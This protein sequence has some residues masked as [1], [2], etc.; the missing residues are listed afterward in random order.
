MIT[1]MRSNDAYLGLPHDVFCFTMIQEI[2]A[3]SVSAELGSYTHMV[4][5]LHLYEND[6]RRAETFLNEGFQPTEG[7]MR[8]MPECDPWK[9]IQQ[10]L[11]AEREIR[12]NGV[13]GSKSVDGLD[14]YW[15][16]IVRLLQIFRPFNGIPMLTKQRSSVMKCHPRNTFIS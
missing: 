14:D 16:D 2:I 1:H 15:A 13:P 3:K 4:G 7:L 10:V 6:F 11:S 9:A 5:S 8:K 12:L